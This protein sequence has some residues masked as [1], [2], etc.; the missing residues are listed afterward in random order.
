MSRHKTY[1]LRPSSKAILL[2]RGYILK[3]VT[4]LKP[5]KL[6]DQVHAYRP[7]KELYHEKCFVPKKRN[8]D[9]QFELPTIESYSKNYYYCVNCGNVHAKVFRK[10]KYIIKMSCPKCDSLIAGPKVALYKTRL[11]TCINCG[12]AK[13][14]SVLNRNEMRYGLRVCEYSCASAYRKKQKELPLERI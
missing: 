4:C 14:K 9:S 12:K 2:Q 6:G 13:Q 10:G 7:L 11:E 8:W 3:C 1:I 5:I